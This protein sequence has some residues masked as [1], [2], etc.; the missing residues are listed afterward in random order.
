MS[1]TTVTMTQTTHSSPAK[2]P[3]VAPP[4]AT[5]GK[6]RPVISASVLDVDKAEWAATIKQGLEAGADTLHFDVMDGHFVPALSFGPGPIGHLRKHFPGVVFDCHFMVTHPENFVKPL[7]DVVSDPVGFTFHVEATE[8]RG[9]TRDVIKQVRDAGMRVGIA[10]SPDTPVEAVLPFAGEVDMV[11]VMTVRPGLGGQSFMGDMMPK[12]ELLR[13]KFPALDIQVDG[14]V[15]PGASVEAV[16]KAGATNIVSG[17]GIYLAADR[18]K[19]VADMRA[20][21]VNASSP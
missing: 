4:G 2:T 3:K 7:R 6:P 17:S 19:A 20:A 14:G 5:S 1:T 11:L 15:K 12:I 21:V 16:A 18:S 9:V 10:L 8:P 13:A